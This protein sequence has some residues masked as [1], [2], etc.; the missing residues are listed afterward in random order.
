MP[1][2]SMHLLSMVILLL[3]LHLSI[4]FSLG[5]GIHWKSSRKLTL[6]AAAKEGKNNNSNNN[7]VVTNIQYW[8]GHALVIPNA[9]NNSR[10]LDFTTIN[11][12]SRPDGGSSSDIIIN[13]TSCSSNIAADDSIIISDPLRGRGSR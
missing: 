13:I 2:A 5:S 12:N 9:G 11:I 7:P 3:I 6:V 4:I 1:I 10:K 8:K